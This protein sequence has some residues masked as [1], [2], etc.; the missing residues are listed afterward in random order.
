MYSPLTVILVCP[1]LVWIR[2]R[3]RAGTVQCY[4]VLL[5]GKRRYA[6]AVLVKV[7]LRVHKLGVRFYP[8]FFTG[9]HTRYFPDLIRCAR[10]CCC[11]LREVYGVGT[12]Q[13]VITHSDSDFF[14]Q[15]GC[16]VCVVIDHLLVVQRFIKNTHGVQLYITFGAT[17]YDILRLRL[18]PGCRIVVNH[19][20]DYAVNIDI[21]YITV[22][23][24]GSFD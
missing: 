1:V 8:V 9:R 19:T 4:I 6:V 13:H 3:K 10:K 2:I 15:V 14:L 5:T 12:I 11:Y 21:R 17:D 18:S 20:H 24:G 7:P 23:F 22:A 16:I